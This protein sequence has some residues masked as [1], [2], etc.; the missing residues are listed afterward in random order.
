LRTLRKVAIIAP[1]D[2]PLL[3]RPITRSD[4]GYFMRPAQIRA[5]SNAENA[6]TSAGF[7]LAEITDTI[8]RT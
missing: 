5:A 8:M 3:V 4:D 2:G 1:R 7:T 6:E